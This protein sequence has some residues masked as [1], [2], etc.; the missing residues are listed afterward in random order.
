MPHILLEPHLPGVTGLLEFRKDTA[1]PLRELTQILLRGE[2][3][4][5]AGERELIATVVSHRN[6]CT[7]CMTSH[8]AAAD[9]CLGEAETARLVKENIQIA[10]VS[11]KMKAMLEIAAAVQISG[12]NVTPALIETAKN[13]QATDLEIHD[14]V[15]IAA[16]FC[17]YNRYV[18]GL[19]TFAPTDATYYQL[20]GERLAN[21]GYHRMPDAY[22]KLKQ[23]PVK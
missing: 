13:A 4:L 9:A 8:T 3:T 5:T 14:T 20:M 2:S 10:P 7:F 1:E 6:D 12:K 16:L 18:D 22:E 11:E 15:M 23:N 19:G 21:G 17:F